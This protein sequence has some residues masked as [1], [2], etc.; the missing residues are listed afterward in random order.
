[1]RFFLISAL[2]ILQWL[3]C[4]PLLGQGLHPIPAPADPASKGRL[5]PAVRSV[6]DS[7]YFTVTTVPGTI[8]QRTEGKFRDGV[9][10][11]GLDGCM[12][13]IS[14]SW[15]DL[16]GKPNPG[17]IILKF[18]SGKGWM[19]ETGYSADGPDGT[20][21]ALSKNGVWCFVRGQWDGGDDADPSHVPSDIYQFII[22]CAE[23]DST[24]RKEMQDE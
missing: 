13:V 10:Q 14:G 8:V 17:E 12:I 23:F 18:L 2:V 5:S 6:C 7:L 4:E 3:G 21:F 20:S 9:F 19:E 1:M 22:V 16:S 11:S 24:G 15:G